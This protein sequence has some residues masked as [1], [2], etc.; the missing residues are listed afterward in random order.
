[1]EPKANSLDKLGIFVG[2]ALTLMTAFI[3]VAPFFIA[4]PEGSQRVI[5]QQQTML[6]TVFI[7]LT[8]FLYGTSVGKKKDGETIQMLADTTSKVVSKIPGET[9]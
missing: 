9:K 3:T 7:A 5:D 8:S 4:V 2:V 6:Q 1:M